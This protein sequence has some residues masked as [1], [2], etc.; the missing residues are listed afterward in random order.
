MDGQALLLRAR[1]EAARSPDKLTQPVLQLL[2][3]RPGSFHA[4][5]TAADIFERYRTSDALLPEAQLMVCSSVNFKRR[6][7]VL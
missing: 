2:R 5:A 3:S 4:L 1:I 6:C 7:S